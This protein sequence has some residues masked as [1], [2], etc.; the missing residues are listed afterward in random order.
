MSKLMK[1]QAVGWI[2]TSHI[3]FHPAVV[4]VARLSTVPAQGLFKPVSGT[5]VPRLSRMIA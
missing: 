1:R 4:I 2:T 5:E 3:D